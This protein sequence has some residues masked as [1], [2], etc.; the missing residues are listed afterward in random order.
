MSE[1]ILTF[2]PIY[3]QKLDPKKEE[4]FIHIQYNGFDSS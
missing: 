1:G 2:K 3:I 4:D